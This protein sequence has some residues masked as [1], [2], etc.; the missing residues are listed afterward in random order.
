M[1]TDRNAPCPCGSG[2]KYKHCCG[3]RTAAGKTYINAA[4]EWLDA[5]VLNGRYPDLYGFLVNVDH[6]IPAPEIWNR[7]RFW[8]EQYMRAGEN[9]TALFHDLV[10]EETARL[11]EA[12]RLDGYAPPFC[13][14][15]C[16]GCCCQPVACTDEEAE[17]IHSYCERNGIPVD[18]GKLERQ[19]RFMRF[20]QNGDFTGAP[21]WDEQ[22]ENDRSC[23]FLNAADS[24][25]MI[26][27]VRPF[28]CR[29]QMAESGEFCRPIKGAPDPRAAAIQYAECS[30]IL[31]AVFTVHHDSVGKMMACL[32]L[33]L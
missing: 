32:L 23:V 9:R 20:D 28:V 10:D 26:W 3:N 22:P 29:N 25:C 24:S 16:A 13:S 7:L 8:T 17:L 30:Y 14:K 12:D 4:H 19:L 21:E 2:E 15:G 18:C 33:N 11:L 1:K 6:E 31:S 27:D 5:H